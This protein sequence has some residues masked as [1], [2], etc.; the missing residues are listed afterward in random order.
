MYLKE[1]AETSLQDDVSSNEAE[2]PESPP[3]MVS[4][5]SDQFI[6]FELAHTDSDEKVTAVS[7]TDDSEDNILRVG[8]LRS[9]YNNE[10]TSHTD[11][12]GYSSS[13]NTKTLLRAKKLQNKTTYKEFS[14]QS[15]ACNEQAK[16][17]GMQLCSLCK[18]VFV[19]I[20]ICLRCYICKIKPNK[21][22]IPKRQQK[23]KMNIP[24]NVPLTSATS[25]CIICQSKPINAGFIH[26][27]LTHRCVCY[28]CGKM[29]TKRRQPCPICRRKVSRVTLIVDS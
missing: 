7:T 15:Y 5:D 19:N 1:V 23:L 14:L 17:D 12:A 4:D 22:N 10:I 11:H 18:N 3:P 9:V 26:G 24:E 27:K 29:I 16:A 8:I 21:P 6:E 20:P 28:K 2:P 13:E 25:L